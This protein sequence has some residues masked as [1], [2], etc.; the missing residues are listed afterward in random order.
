MSGGGQRQIEIQ[1]KNQQQSAPE[2]RAKGP[3]PHELE[4]KRIGCS[5][6][7]ESELPKA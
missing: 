2:L 5:R 4:R 6:T 7:L 3:S 1:D